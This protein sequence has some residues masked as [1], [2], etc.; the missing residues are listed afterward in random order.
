MMSDTTNGDGRENG[1]AEPQDD[2]GTESGGTQPTIVAAAE[3]PDPTSSGAPPDTPSR[4]ID[5]PELGD[6][7]E[8]DPAATMEAIQ[9]AVGAGAATEGQTEHADAPPPSWE[10]PEPQLYAIPSVASRLRTQ[11]E[12]REGTTKVLVRQLDAAIMSMRRNLAI[13][14]AARAVFYVLAAGLIVIVGYFVAIRFDGFVSAVLDARG[15][16]DGRYFWK[17]LLAIGTP[18]LIGL[19]SAGICV[20]LALLIQNRGNTELQRALDHI[21]RMAREGSVAESRSRALTQIL[22]ETLLNARQAFTLQL[23]ISRV[24]FGVGII[25]LFTFIGSLFVDNTVFTGGAVLSSVLSFAAAALFNPQRQIGSDLANI[26]Q[27]EA[28]LGGYTR[29]AALIEDY[30]VDVISECR[31]R[32]R[33]GEARGTVWE[34]VEHLTSVLRSAVR[35]IDDHVQAEDSVSSRERWLMDRLVGGGSDPRANRPSSNGATGDR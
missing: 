27:L 23:W 4:S 6:L 3:H 12:L 18:V 16:P 22:E 1:V 20:A 14:T 9:N 21:S 19:V 7:A 35:A 25:L 29:Q 10:A 34:G 31:D 33:P 28:I 8:F 15:N 32:Q 30:V 13:T 26:T 5:G 17:T 2:Q 11:H 24:L